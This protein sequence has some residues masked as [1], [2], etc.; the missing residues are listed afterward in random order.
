MKCQE[1]TNDLLNDYNQESLEETLS[2]NIRGHLTACKQCLSRRE[3]IKNITDSLKHSPELNLKTPISELV[4]EKIYTDIHRLVAS[5]QRKP[6]QTT[7]GNFRLILLSTAAVTLFGICSYFVLEFLLTEQKLSP[8]QELPTTE[9][10]TAVISDPSLLLPQSVIQT[11]KINVIKGD[12]NMDGA[13]DIIDSMLICQYILDE[14]KLVLNDLT[15][16]MNNDGEVDIGDA[17]LIAQ[18]VME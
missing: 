2:Q 1:I 6:A 3:E 16:D 8:P 12:I 13:S 17:L 14:K 10:G 9:T 4:D 7:P 11:K 15:A 18:K 5:R